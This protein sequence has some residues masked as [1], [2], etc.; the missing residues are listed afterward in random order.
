MRRAGALVL[1]LAVILACRA[2][3]AAEEKPELI[4]SD[5]SDRYH[6]STCKVAQKIYPDEKLTFGTPEEALAA[7]LNPCKKCNPPASSAPPDDR[8]KTH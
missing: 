8:Q 3:A 5:Y 4:A 6:W 1:A 7:G 2:S